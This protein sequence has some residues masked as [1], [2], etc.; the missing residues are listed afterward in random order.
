LGND[1]HWFWL[2]VVVYLLAAAIAAG[3]G[4]ERWIAVGIVAVVGL[5]VVLYSLTRFVL[6][7]SR[8]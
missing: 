6:W 4:A 1:R 7:A 2:A 3:Y 8:R 5:L